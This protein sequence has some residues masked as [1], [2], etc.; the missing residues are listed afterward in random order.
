MSSN[1]GKQKGQSKP[2]PIEGQR[3][4]TDRDSVERCSGK[5]HDSSR[6][7]SSNNQRAPENSPRTRGS[8]H[9]APNQ[10]KTPPERGRSKGSSSAG[11]SSRSGS[12]G[13]SPQ[14]GGGVGPG[15]AAL[16][17]S[18]PTRGTPGRRRGAPKGHRLTADDWEDADEEI[19]DYFAGHGHQSRGSSRRGRW[20]QRQEE[21][22]L[23]MA[24]ALSLS[25]NHAPEGGE[26]RAPGTARTHELT[27]ERLTTLEDVKVTATAGAVAALPSTVFGGSAHSSPMK[28]TT[29]SAGH[30]M[31]T[32]CQHE[33]GVGDDLVVLPCGHRFHPQC[34]SE[35]LL[36]YSRRC[37]VCK[38]DISDEFA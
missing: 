12:L 38:T 11:P 16:G 9:S 22:E 20:E 18:P 32:I 2:R 3:G 24:L 36:N 15:P 29:T 8:P 21:L 4:Q 19:R 7:K 33:Y 13:R 17:K 1:A 14:D 28:A 34:G 35:W 10:N 6:R 26:P 31:C 5:G 25:V 27:Y 37:P 30:E 23:E